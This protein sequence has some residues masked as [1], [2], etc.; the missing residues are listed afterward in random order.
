MSN[1]RPALAH[2]GYGPAARSLHWLVALAVLAQFAVAVAMPEI[3]R[4]TVASP[5]IDLHFSLGTVISLLMA[6]RLIQRLRHPVALAS[7]DSP[8]WENAVARATHLA[9]YV[10]LLAGP[11]LGWA[12]ASAHSLKVNVFGLVTLPDIAA[13]KAAWALK[14]GDLHSLSMWV[15]LAL[16]ALHAGVSLF[17]HFVRHDSVL[18]RMWPGPRNQ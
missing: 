17:H 3:G 9:F 7:T 10:L 14:A 4:K 18:R 5:L 12:S 1:S 11:V 16:I 6:I 2:P 13:P 15:L 8:A